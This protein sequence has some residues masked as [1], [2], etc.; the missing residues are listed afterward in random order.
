MKLVLVSV[1]IGFV[2]GLTF[3]FLAGRF[4]EKDEENSDVI[5]TLCSRIRQL[6]KDCGELRDREKNLKEIIKRFIDWST[7]NHSKDYFNKIVK[8]AEFFLKEL[9]S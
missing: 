7:S 6:Q 9:E 5:K 1:T 3:G 2:F 4:M 8:D